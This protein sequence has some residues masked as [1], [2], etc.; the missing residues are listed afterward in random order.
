MA[1]TR[2]AR[3]M[4]LPQCP[5][6]CL[7]RAKARRCARI[8][9]RWRGY[10]WIDG[11]GATLA[12]IVIL[13]CSVHAASAAQGP[14]A[15]IRQLCENAGFV[16]GAAQSGNGLQQDCMQPIIRGTAQP[17]GSSRPLPNVDPQLAQACRGSE[18]APL[19]TST[20]TTLAAPDAALWG[21]W[22]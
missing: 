19:T 5:Y 11:P 13:L 2:N 21:T 20:S 6:T 1:D 3:T 9:C 12:R 10:G 16:Q 15:M 7:W 18:T 4:V 22:R 8:A 14:C 17:A